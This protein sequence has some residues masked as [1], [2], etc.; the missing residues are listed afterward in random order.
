MRPQI[1]V[2]VFA[3]VQLPLLHAHLQRHVIARLTVVVEL[4]SAE[5]LIHV[6]VSVLDHS[7]ILETMY[8]SAPHPLP[9]V[10][11]NKRANIVM[12]QEIVVAEFASARHLS[13]L[14]RDHRLIHVSAVHA[15]VEVREV[16]VVALRL[17]AQMELVFV[18]LESISFSTTYVR[19]NNINYEIPSHF[20]FSIFHCIQEVVLQ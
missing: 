11:V 16:L 20:M 9:L 19:F 8:A 12:H 2:V 10:L 6:L 1:V 18:S 17:I 3:N 15:I 4:V 7:V 14:V 13:M 5:H